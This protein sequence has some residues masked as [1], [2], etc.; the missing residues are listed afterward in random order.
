MRL[1]YCVVSGNGYLLAI[2]RRS[3]GVNYEQFVRK[4]KRKGI[5]YTLFRIDT[6]TYVGV[7]RFGE[8][9]RRPKQISVLS[10]TG[11]DKSFEEWIGVAS[12]FGFESL[13]QL[14]ARP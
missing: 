4:L 14:S 1:V 7:D 6:A 5:R 13:P 12:V 3:T 10:E 9:S 11:A 8:P 2:C